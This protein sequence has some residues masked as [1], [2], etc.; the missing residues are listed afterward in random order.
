MRMRGAASYT[1]WFAVAESSLPVP[2]NTFAAQTLKFPVRLPREFSRK[3]LNNL[4]FRSRTEPAL[5]ENCANSLIFSLFTGNSCGDAFAGSCVHHHALCSQRVSCM[6]CQTAR[7]FKGLAQRALRSCVSGCALARGFLVS[8][9]PV[10]ASW[11]PFPGAESRD[12]FAS[13]GDRFA[14]IQRVRVRT[15]CRVQTRT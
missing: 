11:K 5:V 1:P 15:E 7:R 3:T 8:A 10:S 14:N 6:V 13:V 2:L 4:L 9:P 12:R